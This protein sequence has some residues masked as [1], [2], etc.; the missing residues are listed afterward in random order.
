[1]A[2]M[3]DVCKE[4]RDKGWVLSWGQPRTQMRKSLREGKCRGIEK[5]LGDV[6]TKMP[7]QSQKYR[8][9]IKL[10]NRNSINF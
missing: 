2:C 4:P 10:Q 7:K 3:N 6:N 9:S 8:G 5:K 1:M